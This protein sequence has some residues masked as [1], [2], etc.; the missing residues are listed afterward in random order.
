LVRRAGLR[1]QDRIPLPSLFEVF[2]F[3]R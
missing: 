1:L 3:R 2:D